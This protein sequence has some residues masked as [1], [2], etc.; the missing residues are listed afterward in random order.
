RLMIP[1][2]SKGFRLVH[3]AVIRY[4]SKAWK[5]FQNKKEFL[6]K[7]DIFRSN[8]K[9]WSANG[10]PDDIT[11]T[12]EA[13]DLAAEILLVYL[14]NWSL[15]TTNDLSED[16]KSLCEYCMFLFQHSETPLRP[17]KD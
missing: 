7:E 13:I 8:A 17:I 6:K 9:E 1:V 15:R 11:V 14:R 3:E 12:S 16:N 2:S 5:W 4:W 10:K